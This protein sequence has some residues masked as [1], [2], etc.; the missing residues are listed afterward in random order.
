MAFDVS[1]LQALSPRGE[2]F[3]ASLLAGLASGL[4]GLIVVSLPVLSRR[5]YTTLLGFS[6]GVMFAA[7][8]LTLLQPALESGQFV[9]VVL[10]IFT[11]G[12][13]LL[14]L[15]RS[16]PHLEPHF[17]PRLSRGSSRFGVLL[18]AAITLHNLPEGMAIG[19]AYAHR[20]GSFGLAVAIAIAAQNIPEGLAV[21]LPFY[22]NGSG[23]L[24]AMLWATGSG[25][26]EP[27]AAAAG[28]HLVDAVH[29]L[30]PF[31]LA[32][33][34]GAMV[35]VAADQILPESHSES[36]SKAPSLALLLGFLLVGLL[37]RGLN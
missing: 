36:G 14:A 22:T 26:V 33:A 11:G 29:G 3:L 7:A 24:K 31:G 35:F 1:T 2:A 19:V 18:V 5:V 10:G 8:A 30:I 21:A 17:A 9:M 37:V 12:L 28:F 25:L 27:I 4:G 34:A 20:D 23:R 16:V 15:E 6:A 13:A 32:V